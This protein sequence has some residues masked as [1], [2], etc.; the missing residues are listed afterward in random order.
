MLLVILTYVMV[1]QG[2]ASWLHYFWLLERFGIETT[3]CRKCYIIC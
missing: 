3:S 2:H 1:T